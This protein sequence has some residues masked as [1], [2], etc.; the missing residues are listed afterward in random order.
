ME[1]YWKK[2]LLTLC[3]P[4]C[5]SAAPHKESVELPG[6]WPVEKAKA[7]YAELPWL[8]G[9]NFVPSTAINQLE[10][11]Q[12]DT[13]DPSTIDRELGWA[14]A[15]GMNTMRV[16]LHDICWFE[17][18]EGF[19]KR[20]D[21]YL[22]IADKHGIRTLFVIFDSVWYPLPRA[23]KQPDPTPF[24]HNS[25]WVQSPGKIILADEAK[26]DALKPYVQGIITRYKDDKR[27]LAWDL[28]NEPD[29]ANNGKWGGSAGQDFPPPLK[30]KYAAQLLEKTFAW[31]REVNPSQP[32]TS[33]VWGAPKWFKNAD[34]VD[35]ICLENS[36]VLSFHTYDDPATAKPVIDEVA[37][38]ERPALCTEYM[39]RGAGSTFEGVLPQFKKHRIGAYNWGLVDGKSQTIYPWDS[40]EKKYAAEPQPWFHDVFRGDGTPYSQI[41][42]D[43]I[44]AITAE[45]QATVQPAGV[46]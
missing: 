28:F 4:A 40:W 2:I 5:L 21:Q 6:R 12:A 45:K 14:A 3:V 42:V 37:T 36:D 23:G 13:F 35:R 10:M 41:E 9:A 38:Q 18:K 33:G 20:I 22:E 46:R 17:D 15:I 1:N 43:F 44:K 8:V 19:C 26:Q 31:A 25:G 24:T 7:W 30:L 11:W 29:N 34:L 32:L 27:V 16:F 39:A